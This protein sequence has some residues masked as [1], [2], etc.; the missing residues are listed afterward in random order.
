MQKPS[1]FNVDCVRMYV[2]ATQVFLESNSDLVI[3]NN[4][5]LCLVMLCI[6]Y[7]QHVSR[8][9]ENKFTSKIDVWLHCS[10]HSLV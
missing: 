2:L 5:K 10:C 8:D 1:F 4:H 3:T 7:K 6:H 9:L